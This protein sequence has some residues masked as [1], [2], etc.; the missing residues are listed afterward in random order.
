MT[1]YHSCHSSHYFR[2]KETFD[3]YLNNFEKEMDSWGGGGKGQEGGGG[4]QGAGG[5]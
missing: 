4:Q 3:E 1:V 5:L 2:T